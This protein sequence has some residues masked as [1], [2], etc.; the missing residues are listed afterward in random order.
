MNEELIGQ[1]SPE[2][3][4]E[5]K[6]KNPSGLYSVEV[7]GHIAYFKMPNRQ[8]INCAMSQITKESQPLDYF[9][10]IAK[11][12]KVGGSDAILE[13]DLMF[14]ELV[15]Q[16]KDIITFNNSKLVKL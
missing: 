16:L 3:I 15:E 1:I 7:N 14:M 2:E 13:D 12:T 4:A 10:S 6:K 9:E 5:L 8:V 11:D